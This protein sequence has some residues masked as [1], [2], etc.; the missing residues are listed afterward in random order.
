MNLDSRQFETVYNRWYK[1]VYYFI[2]FKIRDEEI[3]KD[4][5]SEVFLT[6]MKSWK[7]IPQEDERCRGYLFVIAKSR[8]IDYF[9]S[10]HYNRSVSGMTVSFDESDEE[11][12][13]DRV[14]SSEPLPEEY[15][16]ENES[17]QEVLKMLEILSPQDRD[18]LISRYVDDMSYKEL[19]RVY[20]VSEQ[21]LRK[22]VERA[23][24]KIKNHLG[25]GR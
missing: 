22:R 5:T 11:N 6:A 19:A 12:F 23:L 3:A 9:R 8:I 18:L 16:A 24:Q 17:K 21:S 20:E 14:A 10:A 7:E 25:V 4:I 13:F 1:S 15:F 2:V